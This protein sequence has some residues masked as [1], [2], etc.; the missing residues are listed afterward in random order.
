[1]WLL[2]IAWF[3]QDNQQHYRQSDECKV[4]IEH[5]GVEPHLGHRTTIHA[6]HRVPQSASTNVRYSHACFGCQTHQGRCTPLALNIS[7]Q[8][9]SYAAA[10]PPTHLVST[11]Q[12][13]PRQRVQS[14]KVCDAIS[15]LERVTLREEAC[16]SGPWNHTSSPQPDTATWRHSTSSASKHQTF[17]HQH[18]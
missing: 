3:T 4:T 11:M 17:Q 13:H 16:S 2:D 18:C 12:Q 14:I 6:E 1:M 9:R 15:L 5:I 8:M 7:C 10:T